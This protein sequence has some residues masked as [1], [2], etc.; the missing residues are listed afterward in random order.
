MFSKCSTIF[1]YALLKLQYSVNIYE[2]VGP[3]FFHPIFFFL[4]NSLLSGMS[5]MTIK[6]TPPPSAQI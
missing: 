4:G 3:T 6:C 2:R 5:L 1:Q